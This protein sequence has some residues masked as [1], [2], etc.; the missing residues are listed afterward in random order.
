MI[1][2]DPTGREIPGTRLDEK[3]AQVKK[4]YLEHAEKALASFRG[5]Q[6]P[7]KAKEAWAALG[8][9]L[10]LRK[11]SEDPGAAVEEMVALRDAAAK[12]SAM[13]ESI[14]DLLRRID[15]EEGDGLLQVARMD[16]GGEDPSAGLESLFQVIR[17]FPGLPSA[18]RAAEALA[19]E[20]AAG[21]HGEA[22]A[23]LEREHL[24]RLALR[25]AD[26][27][28]RD[29]KRKEAAEAWAKVAKEFEGTEAGAAAA[30]R[31]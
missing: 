20:K 24:A 17:E 13:R 22:I 30:E 9:A 7:E 21:R 4:T 27:L 11:E 12:G 14:D 26:R 16:L 15:E 23:R 5:G 2:A 6:K 10:R 18:K 31:K 28:A 19:A 3:Q 29:G 1:F 8:K 25:A